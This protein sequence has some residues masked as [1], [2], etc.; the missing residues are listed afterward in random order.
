MSFRTITFVLVAS[1]AGCAAQSSNEGDDTDGSLIASSDNALSAFGKQLVGGYKS[2][3][4]YPRFSL[5]KDASYSWD[6]G[7]RCITAP[8]PSGDVGRFTI[9]Q[10]YSGRKYVRLLSNDS[11]TTRWFRVDSLKPVTLVGVFGTTGTFKLQS[12]VV[13]GGCA[14]T[15]ECSAGEQCVSSV[16]TARPSC[17]QVTAPDGK[18]HARNFAAGAYAEADAWAAKIA[19]GGAYGI[20][21]YTCEEV[22]ASGCTE[23]L[24]PVC[25]FVSGTDAEKTLGNACEA[26]RATVAAAGSGGDA[27]SVTAKGACTTGAPRCATYAIGTDASYAYYVHDFSSQFAADAW[28]AINASAI[29]PQVYTGKCATHTGCT[30]EYNPVCGGVRSDAARTFGNRCMFEASVRVSSAATG[31]SKGYAAP[32]ECTL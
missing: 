10:D 15:T 9:W 16:C 17:A 6:T 13:I 32:G 2:D 5:E 4:W 31:W 19:A 30:K 29:R 3:A 18:F 28:I 20:S 7:I 25:A 22:A 27:V 11:R 1:L 14:A 24:N 21:L 8:C 23:E 12:P 26:R